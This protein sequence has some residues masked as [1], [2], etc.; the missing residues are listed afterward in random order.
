MGAP[1]RLTGLPHGAPVASV[2]DRRNICRYTVV[3]TKAWLGWWEDQEFRSTSAHLVDL[4]LR[5][6]MMTV[7]RLPP[8]D[9][10]VWF[11]P[12]GTT[13]TDWIEA[14]LIE[15]KRRLF[16]PRIVRLS[17]PKPFPYETFKSVV[18]GPDALG[19]Q[20]ASNKWIPESERDNW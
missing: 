18:Y 2:D 10:P 20:F 4:S 14:K 5:G 11:C 8:P 3:Q 16:G 15:A 7:D 6:C 19:G 13:P 17:F 9:Q 12:P 1:K